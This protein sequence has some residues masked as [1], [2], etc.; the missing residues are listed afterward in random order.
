MITPAY[1]V[2]A[3]ERVLP[4]MAL[5][6]TTGSLDARVAVTRA[7]N[8]ATA[9]NSSGLVATVNA[10]L[11]R[12]DYDPLTLSCKGLLI[13]ES[14][15]NFLQYS[16]RPD[17]FPWITIAAVSF[18]TAAAV[19]PDGNTT[20]VYAQNTG[21]AVSLFQQSV[22]T[23]TCGTGTQTCTVFA[24]ANTANQ[25]TLN[26]YFV[27][28]AELNVTFTLTGSGS[29]SDPANSK[30]EAFSNGWYRCS[31]T[32]PARTG[33]GV[34]FDTR[35][36]PNG[37]GN[38]DATGCYFWGF[39]Q[40]AGAFATSY[41]PTTTTSVTR[42]ADVAVMTGTD[43]SSWY[44]Q[45]QGSFVAEFIPTIIGGP[46]VYAATDGTIN[47]RIQGPASDVA[48]FLV[49]SDGALQ[50][51]LDGGT[52]PPAGI[53][54]IASAYAENNFALSLNAGTVVTDTTGTPPVVDRFSIGSLIGNQEWLNGHIRAVRY[55][56]LRLTNAEIQ[57]FSKG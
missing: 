28:D 48:Q 54:K 46:T 23:S 11:P 29:T 10:N 51:L 37:R 19:A 5:D 21:S 39:G 49:S 52:I 17:T 14:R 27:G 57:A 20:A 13:E 25:F 12:F 33:V 55:Y 2:T 8:T 56:P 43:F 31:V 53:S 3:T 30:I 36:W 42:N 22:P 18:T 50:A 1:S 38:S 45:S 4:R 6:F 16:E 47:N 7:L 15:T 32:Y 44:N 34:G 41:I 26:P 40:E 9:I 35:F 24:K